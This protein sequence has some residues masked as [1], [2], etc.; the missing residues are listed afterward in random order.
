MIEKLEINLPADLLKEIDRMAR[1]LDF[2]SREELILAAIRR[3]VDYYT[4]LLRT[5][6]T[7]AHTLAQ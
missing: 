7:R 4:T 6:N 3:L 2:C 5:T 1:A